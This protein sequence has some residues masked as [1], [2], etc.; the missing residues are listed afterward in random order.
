MIE[1]QLFLLVHSKQISHRD[2]KPDNILLDSNYY[3]KICDFGFSKSL[4]TNGFS[5]SKVGT[6]NYL[7]PE[8]IRSTEKQRYDGKKADIY[9]FG[10]TVYSIISCS[11]PYSE[12]Y[13]PYTPLPILEAIQRGERPKMSSE[14]FPK[15]LQ[16][17]INKCWSKNIEE[18]PESFES[19][20]NDLLNWNVL[21]CDPK[22]IDLN[23]VNKFLDYCKEERMEEFD[24]DGSK[25]E[26]KGDKFFE[27]KNYSKAL[28]YY[29]ISSKRNNSS[30]SM[31]IGDFYEN[32]YGD[33]KINQDKALDYYYCRH[34]QKLVIIFINWMILLIINF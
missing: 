6:P 29:Q 22:K 26:I 33:I 20:V 12:Y 32:G 18:R 16:D 8:V 24:E 31:K 27:E 9:A 2:L 23:Q 28:K 17:F 5:S 15:S 34:Y 25:M 1:S 19:I 14:D 30:S 10:M 4:T 21:I 7:A 11:I 13:N 3:P